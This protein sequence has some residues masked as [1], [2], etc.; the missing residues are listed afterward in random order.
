MIAA[1]SRPGAMIADADVVSSQPM[2]CE[3]CGE[4]VMNLL[5]NHPDGQRKYHACTWNSTARAWAPHSC[6]TGRAEL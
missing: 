2:H 1:V 4:V 3:G 6:K 5:V